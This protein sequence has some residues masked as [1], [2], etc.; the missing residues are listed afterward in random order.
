[1]AP[2]ICVKTLRFFALNHAPNRWN[3]RNDELRCRKYIKGHW[4]AQ[5]FVHAKSVLT[6]SG[7]AYKTCGLWR[8][9]KVQ[10]GAVQHLCPKR[11]VLLP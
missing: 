8:V 7:N 5:W 1:M 2:R 11:Y 9:L 4:F 3:Q 10:I 6:I